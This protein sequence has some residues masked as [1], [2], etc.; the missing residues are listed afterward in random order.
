MKI[1]LN[2]ITK[3]FIVSAVIV[4]LMANLMVVDMKTKIMML[5]ISFILFTG[6]LVKILW[7]QVRKDR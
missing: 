3:V 2:I 5:N 4:G 6:S 1:Y 7:F